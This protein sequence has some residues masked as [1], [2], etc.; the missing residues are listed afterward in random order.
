M[1]LVDAIDRIRP[2][3]VQIRAVGPGMSP[4]GNTL[5]T[6]FVVTK[7]RHVV[8]AKHVV[9]AIDYGAGQSLHVAFAG[10][11]V[12]TRQLKIRAN[13]TGTQA[14][15]L[16]T[17][18]EHDL[19]LLEVPGAQNLTF[20]IQLGDQLI[21]TEPR[22][23]W[24]NERKLREGIELAVSGYPLAQPSLVTNAGVLASSFSPDGP[25]GN[26]KD[27]YLGD[28]TANP[29]NSG[30]PVYTVGDAGIVGVCVAGRLAPIV[31]GVGAHAA[32]LTVV[33]PVAEVQALMARNGL[34]GVQRSVG[35]TSNPRRG[36]KGRK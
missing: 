6:G 26:W 11:D 34:D 25:V 27:R 23:A 35:P 4:G 32:G 9:D 5:G 18:D 33:V 19:A 14:T 31:G 22:A 29:G 28:F 7:D 8:T 1:N 10:P 24:L 2:S 13:F 21:E 16:D 20:R 17:V 12:D 3:V 36:R 30:G 15:V